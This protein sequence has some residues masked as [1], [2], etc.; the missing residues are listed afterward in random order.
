[1]SYGSLFGTLRRP[2]QHIARSNYRLPRYVDFPARKA[3]AT[4]VRINCWP[5]HYGLTIW[6]RPPTEISPEDWEDIARMLAAEI[7]YRKAKG[8]PNPYEDASVSDPTERIRDWDAVVE[9]SRNA[10]LL[11]RSPWKLQNWVKSAYNAIWT[12]NRLSNPRGRITAS[13]R[14][15]ELPE[16]TIPA[17]S[18]FNTRVKIH[19]AIDISFRKQVNNYEV[20]QGAKLNR[21]IKEKEKIVSWWNNLCS[22]DHALLQKEAELITD[23]WKEAENYV[24]ERHGLPRIGEGW[25]SEAALLQLVKDTFPNERVVHH[26]RPSWLGRQHI[27]VFLPNRKV[28]I[29]YQGKQHFVPVDFFGGWDGLHKTQKRDKRK[30]ELCAQNGVRLIY[31]PFDEPATGPKLRALV[32]ES[33]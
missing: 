9:I 2:Y 8:S 12:V 5:E 3:E 32:Q 16:I 22:T 33:E 10:V 7:K 4:E 27:D 23:F 26:A 20:S 25:V 30:R 21:V 28:A 19:A 14:W 11:S 29:E 6:K 18:P 17:P 15:Q 31:C 1:M 13:G 24:R